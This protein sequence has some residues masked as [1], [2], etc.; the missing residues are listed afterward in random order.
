MLLFRLKEKETYD[1]FRNDLLITFG[2]LSFKIRVMSNKKQEQNKVT[3][4]II[5]DRHMTDI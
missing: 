3:E 4:Y 1:L 5:Y 2:K